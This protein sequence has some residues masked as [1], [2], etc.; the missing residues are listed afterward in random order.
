LLC[1]QPIVWKTRTIQNNQQFYIEEQ[2]SIDLYQNE[3]VTPFET[4]SIEN[5]FDVSFKEFSNTSGLLYLHT[6]R[7]VKTYMVKESPST[8]METF[9]KCK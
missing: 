3:V 5:I 7:G 6:N 2:S 9:H 1:S 8:W 4:I